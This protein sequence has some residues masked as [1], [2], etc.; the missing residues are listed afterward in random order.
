MKY[1]DAIGNTHI[2]FGLGQSG[3]SCAR[4]FDRIEQTYLL[5]DTRENPPGE[6][7]IEQLS[8]CQGFYFGEIDESILA[9]C[10]QL[11]VS[12][13]ISL[14]TP[15]VKKAIALNIDVCGDVEIF[16]RACNKPI[17]A[18]TGSN[19]KST[20]TDLTDKLINASGIKAQKG[21]NIGLPVLDFLP[22]DKAELY[23]LE[24]S[25]FQL[26]TTDSLAPE[27]AV[28]LNL[29]EDH[30]D[31]YSGFEQYCQSKQKIYQRAKYKVFNFDDALTHPQNIC[32]NDLAFSLMMPRIDQSLFVSYIKPLPID[33]DLLSYE[34]V[35]D[36]V[37]VV[38]SRLLNI[39]GKHNFAN[40]LAC[41]NILTCLNIDISQSILQV[42]QRYKGL[43][44]RFQLVKRDS[45][46]EWI[47]DSKATN[48]GATIAALDSLELDSTTQLIL[49]AGGDSKQSQLSPLVQPLEDKVSA[50]VL[51]GKDAELFARLSSNIS[52]YLVENMQQAV[53][54]AKQLIDG[55]TV[56]LLSPACSS[57]DM[58]KNFEARGD[59]FIS[60]V[61]ACA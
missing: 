5:L 40:V 14:Q 23:V 41:L 38:S 8:H 44:H 20:V 59:A 49:I 45:Q 7:E 52:S 54:K 15:L 11:V 19:G 53:C 22:Q 34:L 1:M 28:L 46:C 51:L 48:V 39:A 4:Y 35:V 26:D 47:N 58:F 31:R 3:L 2:I 29:S 21:G 9:G 27:V 18:I 55:K 36:D 50:L 6:I 33:N 42:L 24:L 30:L 25:S 12:P 56:I 57:L 60:E 10:C 61:R 43:K 32:K 37:D 17:V 13:G 16:S